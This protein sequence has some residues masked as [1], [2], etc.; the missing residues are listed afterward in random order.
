MVANSA[1][2]LVVFMNFAIISPVQQVV[3]TSVPSSVQNTTAN[4]SGDGTTN[5][6]HI[7][8]WKVIMPQL[9]WTKAI[10][11]SKLSAVIHPYSLGKYHPDVSKQKFS[12][13]IW[14]MFA[15]QHSWI[16]PLMWYHLYEHAEF[17]SVENLNLCP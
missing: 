13:L 6:N 5:G 3:W 4:L 2:V 15:F 1:K 17:I 16:R 12:W 9:W 10:A 7:L 11:G 8:K 14:G